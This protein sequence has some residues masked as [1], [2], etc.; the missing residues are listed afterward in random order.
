MNWKI[1]NNDVLENPFA[2]RMARDESGGGGGGMEIP[3]PL[4]VTPQFKSKNAL[5]GYIAMN[6]FINTN[7]GNVNGAQGINPSQAAKDAC[8]NAKILVETGGDMFDEL[9]AE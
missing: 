2:P 5:A 8:V 4:I 1:L 7:F 3:Q 9:C 6:L